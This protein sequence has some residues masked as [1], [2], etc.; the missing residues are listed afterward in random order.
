MSIRLRLTLLYSAILVLTLIGFSTVLYLTLARGTLRVLDERLADE[1]GRLIAAKEFRLDSVLLPVRQFAA[2]ATFIQTRNS[3]GKAT[4]RTDNLNDYDLPLSDAGLASVLEGKDWIET[5]SLENVRLRTLTRPVSVRSRVIGM[6]Q[7][8]RALTDQDQSLRTLRGLLLG[9]SVVVT[10]L[11]CGAGWLLAGTALRPINRITQ[12]AAR[13]GDERDFGRRITHSGPADEIGRLATTINVMLEELQSAY[14]QVE[15]ALLAQRRFV[16]DASHELRTPLT[17]VRGN[18]G[19]LQREPPINEDD[20]VAVLDDMVGETDRLI[21]LVNDLLVLARADAGRALP[22]E[23][24]ALRPV[25]E[26]SSRTIR[27][28]DPGRVVEYPDLP[29]VTVAGNRDAIK[30]ILLILLDNALKFTPRDATISIMVEADEDQVILSVRDTGPGI[31]PKLLPHIFERFVRGT[32]SRT[33]SGAGLGLAIAR[34]LA[35]MQQGR[36]TVESA[37]GQGS[38]FSLRLPRVTEPVPQTVQLVHLA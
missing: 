5:T 24:V 27:T 8:A 21:R 22:S 25:V 35:E 30:Q 19:L 28:L 6:V 13:I 23:P 16:A 1:A 32:A 7:I 18:I 29:D 10:I 15:Q 31:E 37:P 2:P 3:E 11:A 36:L 38:T 9:G 34:T 14:R 20:R 33:G 17:T 12:T 26:E 4:Y